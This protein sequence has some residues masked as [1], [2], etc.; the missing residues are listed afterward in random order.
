[1]ASPSERSVTVGSEGS[2]ERS[3]VINMAV[4]WPTRRHGHTG[5]HNQPKVLS[6][7]VQACLV[8]A[9][10]CKIEPVAAVAT[11]TCLIWPHSSHT[12]SQSGV[13]QSESI[14]ELYESVTRTSPCTGYECELMH[15]ELMQTVGPPLHTHQLSS[16]PLICHGVR[17][18]SA[19]DPS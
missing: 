13:P 17:T 4:S 16:I 7:K 9:P 2:F 3:G 10:P 12:L 14:M 6:G 18:C 1:M 15:S 19:G 5:T 11:E 8:K